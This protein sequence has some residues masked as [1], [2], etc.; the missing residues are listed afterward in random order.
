M[1]STTSQH[2]L[3]AGIPV[4]DGN[5]A[6][7]D[8]AVKATRIAPAKPVDLPWLMPVKACVVWPHLSLSPLKSLTDISKLAACSAAEHEI[9]ADSTQGVALTARMPVHDCNEASAGAVHSRQPDLPQP[10]MHAALQFLKL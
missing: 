7:V 2:L 8:C 1:A 5:E 6:N 4:H 9:A 10:S 3:A